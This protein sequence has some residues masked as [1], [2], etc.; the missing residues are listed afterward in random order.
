MA[1]V[2]PILLVLVMG[3]RTHKMCVNTQLLIFAY[4]FVASLD[5]IE[6]L[7]T[8]MLS[9]RYKHIIFTTEAIV[10]ISMI[11]SNSY[12]VVTL[13][14]YLAPKDDEVIVE[15]HQHRFDFVYKA[16]VCTVAIFFCEV[17]M[18]V[19]RI[20]ILRVGVNRIL[21]GTFILW[22]IKN[23]FFVFF[24][25]LYV[26]FTKVRKVF[27]NMQCKPLLDSDRAFFKPEKRDAYI[28]S[29]Q[30]THARRS[31]LKKQTETGQTLLNKEQKRVT[32]FMDGARSK[33][34]QEPSLCPIQEA[35]EVYT[36]VVS[37]L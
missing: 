25:F 15:K 4:W 19:A 28:Y 26:F 1:M 18:L 31:S 12:A 2:M 5:A 3:R 13:C 10:F 9:K 23:V 16:I 33:V 8:A 6:L 22:I 7:E 21:V 36:P 34:R 35:S 17:P 24:I 14:S 29:H 32:F 20:Q 27:R 30:F 11:L 37:L